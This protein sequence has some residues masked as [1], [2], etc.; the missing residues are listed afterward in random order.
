MNIPEEWVLLVFQEIYHLHPDLYEYTIY[1]SCY[2]TND[3]VLY[4]RTYN[5]SQISAV[6]LMDEDL[7]SKDLI[8]FPL[9]NEE[10]ISYIN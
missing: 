3:A 10:Q 6:K 5:N 7:D 8:N 4:Y 2:N 9:I 1:T